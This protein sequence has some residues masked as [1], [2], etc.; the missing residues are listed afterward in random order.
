MPNT[1]NYTVDHKDEI[2]QLGKSGEV[3]TIYR[4]YAMSTG[5]TYFHVDVPEADLKKAEEL[6][7]AK[8][9][10]LDSIK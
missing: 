9:Q 6:L 4:I 8:A 5:G 7:A 1:K 3:I 10:V 2:R